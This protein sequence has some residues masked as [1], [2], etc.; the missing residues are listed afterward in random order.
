[1]ILVLFDLE[2]FKRCEVYVEGKLFISVLSVWSGE[3]WGV[4]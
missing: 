2:F 1:M 3:R 4:F